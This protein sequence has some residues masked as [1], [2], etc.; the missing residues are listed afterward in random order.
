MNKWTGRTGAKVAAWIGITASAVLF[1]VGVAGVLVIDEIGVYDYPSEEA[2][3]ESLYETAADQYTM[4]ALYNIVYGGE[5]DFGDTFFRYGIVRT[6]DPDSVDLS[7][8][9][10][11]LESNFTEEIV[12]EELYVKLYEIGDNTNFYWSDNVLSGYAWESSAE[13]MAAEK[14]LGVYEI[15]YN[16]TDGVFYYSTGEGYYPVR[17]VGI[18]D[19]VEGET[20]IYNFAYDFER[21]AYYYTGEEQTG[22]VSGQ[23]AETAETAEADLS[24]DVSLEGLEELGIQPDM[25]N[26]ILDGREYAY[27]DGVIRVTDESLGEGNITEEWNY[28]VDPDAWTIS[29]LTAEEDTDTYLVAVQFP[30][31]AGYGIS[32][33]LFVQAN[34]F[35]AIG[36]GLRYGVYAIL[37][38]SLAG[39]VLCFVFLLCA[40]GHRR[41]TD[42]IVLTWADRIPFDIFLAVIGTPMVAVG[43]FGLYGVAGFVSMIPAMAGLL[44]ILL[45]EGW[46]LLFAI[47]SFATRAKHG[48]WWENT[49]CWW[50]LRRVYRFVKLIGENISLLWKVLIVI[51]V[52]S[53]AEFWV[54]SWDGI[55]RITVSWLAEK[56]VL[57]PLILL[58]VLQMQKLKEGAE[59]MAEGDLDH[60]IDTEKMFGE[61]RRHGEALNSISTGMSLAVDERMKS[62]R[63]KT[64]LITNV[65]HDI[66]TPLTSIINYVD[67]LEK[68]DLHNEVAEEYLAVLERQS[69]RLKKLIEDLMEASKAS[70]GNL[71]VHL[72]KL[73]AG[74]SLVQIVGEFDE[75]IHAAGLKLL[76][77]KPEQPIYIM[78]DSRHFWRVVDNLMNNICK[79]AQPD[80]RVYVNLEV[81]GELAV[82]TFRNTS[83][84]PL[85]ITSEELMERFV[86]GDSSRNTE[87][88]GLGLSIAKSL[89]DLMQGTFSLYVD[90]D[91]F[92]VVLE[93]PVA[94]EDVE[95]E[96]K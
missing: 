13:T 36:Y 15:V 67:L 96:E 63:F 37:L 19:S 17:E 39:G 78:A 83:R 52:L 82:F 60:R 14:M 93:L 41:G 73:E 18:Y 3:R 22:D 43:M 33:D 42:E 69:A 72:E 21:K 54:V 23:S 45:C 64:E 4:Q 48:K 25:T 44:L 35:A 8:K 40:A 95:Q 51:G 85:N 32:S 5:N 81:R 7:D 10:S 56:V 77:E 70:T 46:M 12:S 34:T 74:V 57:V 29:V 91:L 53:M 31:E 87:G 49:V 86:R 75:K 79:Y 68:E 26:V 28:E 92:K 90:G 2:C 55:G 6:D 61:F 16:R 47:L 84:Y 50:I 24:L 71:A 11:Y 89:M 58:A 20:R 80:T 30:G 94:K 76:V 65:S 38:L 88:S 59:R 1:F 62:E 27:S 9:N 66:K